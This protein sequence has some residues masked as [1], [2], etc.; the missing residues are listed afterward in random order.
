MQGRISVI[1][2]SYNRA[3]LLRKSLLSLSRQSI[4]PYEVI[5]TDDGSSINIPDHLQ[6]ILDKLDFKLKYIWQPDNGFRL[7]KAR[8]NAIR[9]VQGDYVVF[10]DQDIIHT[11]GYIAAYAENMK[12]GEFLTAYILYLS[13]TQ[14]EKISEENILNG[15]F[16]D[17]ISA[18]QIKKMRNLYYKDVFYYYQRKLVLRNDHRPKV[19]GGYFG[20]ALK[21]ILEING[22]DENYV[23][24]GWEDDDFGRRLYKHGVCGRTVFKNDFPIHL[25]HPVNH[26]GS[27]KSVNLDYYNKR[28]PEIK[29]GDIRAVKGLEECKADEALKI[30]KLK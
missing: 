26:D 11:R 7:S 23:G 13:Q 20:V 17:I 6:D 3:D 14:S 9:E 1:I 5:I 15:Q 16:L 10:M 25:Y 28:I 4:L 27:G 18:S 21:H 29:A 24:W 30:I 12:M 19:R 2:S 22:F 8:N